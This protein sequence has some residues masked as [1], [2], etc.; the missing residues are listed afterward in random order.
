MTSGEQPEQPT[1]DYYLKNNWGAAEAWSWKKMTADEGGTFKLE[2]VVFGGTGV[3]YNTAESDEGSTWVAVDDF[4]GDKVAAKDT[5]TFTLNPTAGTITAKLLGKF[6][7]TGGD[8]PEQP[9]TE[10]YLK[11]NWGAAEAWSWKKMT[12]DAGGTFKLE[13][14]VFGGTGVNYNTAESDE[15]STWVAVDDFTGDK[16]AAKDTVTFTLNP[17]AGTITVKLLGKFVATGGGDPE[18]PTTDYYLKNNWGAAE[19]WSWKKMTADAGGTFKLEKV[20][21]GGTGVN[22]NTAESDE[23]STWVA[24]D[25]FTG[26]KVAAKDTVTFTLNPTAGTIT[27]KLLGKFVA[28]G[29]GDPEQPTDTQFYLVGSA[30]DWQVVKETQYTFAATDVEGEYK[31]VTTLTVG[32]AV[33][34]VGVKGETQTWYPDGEGN[35]YIVDA[36]HAGSVTIYFRPAGGNEDWDVFGG[37]IY[38]AK[39]TATDLDFVHTGDQAV[40]VLRD[41]QLFILRGNRMYTVMGIVR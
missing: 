38:I 11:N 1:T 22:Y 36:D 33:K 31:L 8:N 26:D 10:Y 17:T 3:N 29:G 2:K 37:Y 34:V 40:K 5:V 15:G 7:A 27:A 16:V 39:D 23:G 18:Q 19:A 24:V 41:G 20:V 12:A 35:E 30:T 9:T 21:F 13:K 25:D 14:V 32:Q 28:T 6:V 4:T